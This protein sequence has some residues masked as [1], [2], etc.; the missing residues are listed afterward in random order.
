M[1]YPE[2]FL[3]IHYLISNSLFTPWRGSS[4]FSLNVSPLKETQPVSVLLGQSGADRLPDHSCFALCLGEK[5]QLWEVAVLTVALWASF[6]SW[7][8]LTP[9]E[10]L[11]RSSRLLLVAAA[12]FDWGFPL[13]LGLIRSSSKGPGISGPFLHIIECCIIIKI[14][15]KAMTMGALLIILYFYFI[16]N[17]FFRVKIKPSKERLRKEN[18]HEEK[19]CQFSNGRVNRGFLV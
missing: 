12:K 15:F 19:N 4:F 11:L 10:S 8:R 16:F 6:T 3:V 5:L 1:P 13:K 7:R 17:L 18:R 14:I 2:S 9:A